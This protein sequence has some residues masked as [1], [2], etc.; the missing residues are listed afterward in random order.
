MDETKRQIE[1]IGTTFEA[2]EENLAN[3]L[4]HDK[5]NPNNATYVMFAMSVLSDVQEMLGWADTERMNKMINKVKYVISTHLSED[6]N[7]H[8]NIR[9]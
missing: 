6:L 2:I 4:P 8:S 9:G 7:H 1:M 3:Y 5:G